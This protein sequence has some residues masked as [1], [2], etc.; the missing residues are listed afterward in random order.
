MIIS[1]W[2]CPAQ[3]DNKMYPSFYLMNIILPQVNYMRLKTDRA[4]PHCLRHQ[5]DFLG[6][7]KYQKHRLL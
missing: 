3:Q 6:T 5:C 7:R 1:F 4:L 2:P